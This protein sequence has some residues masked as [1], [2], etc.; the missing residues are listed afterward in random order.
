MI[1]GEEHVSYF[2]QLEGAYILLVTDFFTQT[3]FPN[4]PK[5]WR[6]SIIEH[7]HDVSLKLIKE[8]EQVTLVRY[9]ELHQSDALNHDPRF[10]KKD[11]KQKL[12]RRLTGDYEPSSEEEGF[13]LDWRRSFFS[14]FAKHLQSEAGKKWFRRVFNYTFDI[15]CVEFNY[16][17]RWLDLYIG[18]LLNPS[19][20]GDLDIP[21]RNLFTD[22]QQ[23]L[24]FYEKLKQMGAID[25][26]NKWDKK[27]FNGS[28]V[29]AMLRDLTDRGVVREISS[30]DVAMSF[31]TTFLSLSPALLRGYSQMSKQ[32]PK[33]QRLR[34]Q[35]DFAFLKTGRSKIKFE[36]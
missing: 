27:R 28:Y 16:L 7:L 20:A 14:K 24:S 36:E 25:E 23:F 35:S 34:A 31:S 3:D 17:Q 19:P 12:K 22:D 33:K 9:L 4:S 6:L 11:L 26:Q 10:L 21:F 18:R 13:W 29:K 2:E 1:N 15:Y 32:P 5:T 8:F 30:M